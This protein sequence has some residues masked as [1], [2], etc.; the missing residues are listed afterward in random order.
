MFETV[1][2]NNVM[3]YLA[4]LLHERVPVNYAFAKS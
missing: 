4:K 1:V 3:A 2:A